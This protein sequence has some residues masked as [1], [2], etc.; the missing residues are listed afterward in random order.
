MAEEQGETESASTPGV[1]QL[2][3]EHGAKQRLSLGTVVSLMLCS[4]LHPC[5]FTLSISNLSH[6][7]DSKWNTRH[8]FVAADFLVS[9]VA[10]LSL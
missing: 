7:V 4:T 1:R 2:A 3:Q 9:F 10:V 5:P 8:V 6:R